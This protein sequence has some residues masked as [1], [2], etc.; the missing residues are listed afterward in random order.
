[1][2]DLGQCAKGVKTAQWMIYRFAKRCCTFAAQKWP[3]PLLPKSSRKRTSSSLSSTTLTS[4]QP[5]G[6]VLDLKRSK[7]IRHNQNWL[8]VSV[9]PRANIYALG[10][11]IQRRLHSVL[12]IRSP[13][14]SRFLEFCAANLTDF[15]K[16]EV[17][18]ILTKPMNRM[19]KCPS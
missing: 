12:T 15:E 10:A 16:F 2:S 7:T 5:S 11:A 18:K 19:A 4:W 17:L 14:L 9:N 3:R 1:M 8:A 13:E 6:H